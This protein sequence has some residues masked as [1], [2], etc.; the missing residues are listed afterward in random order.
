MP[1]APH[2]VSARALPVREPREELLAPHSTPALVG[3]EGPLPGSAQSAPG[4]CPQQPRSLG[5][6]L[7]ERMGF[8]LLKGWDQSTSSLGQGAGWGIAWGGQCGQCGQCGQRGQEAG[9]SLGLEFLD[10]VT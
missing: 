9:L 10:R 1:S 8:E 7:W 3:G 5:G 4:V 6:V 2:C